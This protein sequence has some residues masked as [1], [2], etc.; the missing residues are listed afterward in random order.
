MNV[1]EEI[2]KY[3]K[4]YTIEK[5]KKHIEPPLSL[6]PEEVRQIIPSI[7]IG[8]DGPTLG[9]L[10]LITDNYFCETRLEGES[11]EFDYLDRKKVFNLRLTLSETSV[12]RA[13]ETIII[14]QIATANILHGLER[15]HS[16]INYA[17]DN[18]EAWI[19]KVL[20]AIPLSLL[21]R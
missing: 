6:C 18:R 4:Y 16:T 1:L 17:G 3:E 12:K 8:L 20:E 10:F 2:K 14:Y 9:S 11:V 5:L 19:K 13:D 15:F 21:L 7:V